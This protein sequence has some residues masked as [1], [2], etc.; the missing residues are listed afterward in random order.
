MKFLLLTNNDID[1]VGRQALNV[2]SSLKKKGH[3][4]KILVLHKLN[5]SKDVFQIKRSFFLRIFQFF[6]N[7]IKKNFFS[8][9]NF[10]FSTIDYEN[11]K[12]HIKENDVVI[13]FSLYKMISNKILFSILEM[14]K[15]IYFRPLD[16]ELATGGCHFNIDSQ[17]KECQKYQNGC[18]N[19]PQLNSLNLFN[20]SKK[21][22]IRKKEIFSNALTR[23]FVPNTFTKKIFL[24]SKIFKKTK[25]QTLFLGTNEKTIK[26][27]SKKKSRQILNLPLD[28]KIILFGAFNL[29]DPHKGGEILKRSIKL[30]LL[31]IRKKSSN[32]NEI[33]KIHLI[34][35]GRK[36]TFN[37]DLP[38]IKWTHLGLISSIKKLNYIYRASNVLV[39]PSTYDVGPHIVTEALLSDLPI[40]AFDQGV[41][42]DTIVNGL[43]GYIIPCFSAKGFAGG[44]FKTLYN[45]KQKNLEKLNK[46]KSFFKW[47]HEAN[48]IIRNARLDLKKIN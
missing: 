12:N 17:N 28:E 1:G 19:C 33:K 21:N 9:F 41:A 23:I 42:Q 27:Y 14:K 46:I 22:L 43:N 31:K 3:K 24:K 6:L 15:T 2:N 36:N 4:S 30:L 7:F 39:C 8:L 25:T 35:I 32:L 47:S 20:I 11:L 29:D 34:T 40:V 37:L 44:I 16:M 38:E 5:N 26:P 48:I 13:I 18:N 45:K 10:G